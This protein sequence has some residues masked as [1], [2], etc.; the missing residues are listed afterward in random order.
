MAHPTTACRCPR[1]DHSAELCEDGP[2]ARWAR[3]DCL[4]AWRIVR[5]LNA[6][7]ESALLAERARVRV[8]WPYGGAV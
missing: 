2:A 8:G 7:D 5:D 4:G 1:G 3:G 6:R